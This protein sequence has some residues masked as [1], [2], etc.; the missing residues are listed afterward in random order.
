MSTIYTL[1]ISVNNKVKNEEFIYTNSVT[2]FHT[3]K[4]D[5]VKHLLVL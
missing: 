2:D 3:H 4:N 1:P 5:S